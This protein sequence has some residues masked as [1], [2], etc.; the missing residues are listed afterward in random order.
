MKI[1]VTLEVENELRDAI[2]RT[3][4]MA[5]RW[6]EKAHGAANAAHKLCRRWFESGSLVTL[7]IDTDTETCEVEEVK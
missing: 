7:V 1:H 6:D 2:T 3:V 4:G 5:G